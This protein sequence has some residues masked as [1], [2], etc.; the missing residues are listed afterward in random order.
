MYIG[1]AFLQKAK[2]EENA[3]N[4]ICAGAAA[5]AVACTASATDAVGCAL[6]IDVAPLYVCVIFRL[7]VRVAMLVVPLRGAQIRSLLKAI[8]DEPTAA[9]AG[10]WPR[11]VF[12][13]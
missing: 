9:A 6:F 2:Q 10:R 12:P 5:A 1:P 8:Y 11:R 7:A 13:V 4:T 3:R